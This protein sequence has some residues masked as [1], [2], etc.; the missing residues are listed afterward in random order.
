MAGK[1]GGKLHEKHQLILANRL[2]EEENRFCADCHAKGSY[3]ILLCLCWELQL[4]SMTLCW[5]QFTACFGLIA[6]V[7][8]YVQ[9][10]YIMGGMFQSDLVHLYSQASNS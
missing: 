8:G 1:G 7:V 4:H 2:R 5:S 9:T 6:I 10:S 3:Q